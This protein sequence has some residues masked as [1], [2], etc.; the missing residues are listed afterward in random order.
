MRSLPAERRTRRDLVLCHKIA[1]A[2]SQRLGAWPS[3]VL[4]TVGYSDHRQAA[5]QAVCLCI[6]SAGRDCTLLSQHGRH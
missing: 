3:R 2:H 4:R 1:S 5:I 6:A